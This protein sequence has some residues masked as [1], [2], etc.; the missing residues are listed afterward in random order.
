M[1]GPT[2]TLTWPNV[3]RLFHKLLEVCHRQLLSEVL[4]AVENQV[5]RQPVQVIV[6]QSFDK[7]QKFDAPVMNFQK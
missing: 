5:G 4:V 3:F 2:Y 6:G 7:A 1:L